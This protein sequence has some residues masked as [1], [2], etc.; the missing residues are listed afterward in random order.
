MKMSD[1]AKNM[2]SAAFTFFSG[3]AVS[4]IVICALCMIVLSFSGIKFFT[5]ESSSMEPKYPKDALVFVKKCEPAR[6]SRGDVITYVLNRDGV[7]VTHRIVFVDKVNE[8]FITKGDANDSEDPNPVLWSNVVGKVVF[9]IPKAGGVFR[10]LTQ[11]SVRPFLIAA[12]VLLGLI[13]VI[14]DIREKYRKKHSESSK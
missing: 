1:K 5:V 12:V 6:L 8:T 2:C 4:F 10:A 3:F 9:G 11:P 13:S 14:G 7:L